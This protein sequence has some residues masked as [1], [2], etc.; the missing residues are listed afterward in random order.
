MNNL[1]SNEWRNYF[2]APIP[3]LDKSLAIVKKFERSLSEEDLNSVGDKTEAFRRIAKNLINA[4]YTESYNS[5]AIFEAMTACVAKRLPTKELCKA[6]GKILV[7]DPDERIDNWH[8]KV[9][10]DDRLK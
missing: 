8:R 2:S 9:Y 6:F 1:D 3:D 7:N 4:V 10:M 5:A